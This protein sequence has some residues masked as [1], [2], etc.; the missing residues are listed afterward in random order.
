MKMK[1]SVCYL[2]LRGLIFLLNAAKRRNIFNN[3]R[4]SLPLP[5]ELKREDDIMELEGRS[6]TVSGEDSVE[7]ESV[8]F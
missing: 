4:S 1:L 3:L 2:Q 5:R 7:M 6:V 8:K